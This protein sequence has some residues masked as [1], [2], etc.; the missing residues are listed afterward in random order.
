METT[1]ALLVMTRGVL[2]W[3][4]NTRATILFVQLCKLWRGF[5]LGTG[6]LVSLAIKGRS[7]LYGG[8]THVRPEREL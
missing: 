1:T 6:F 7:L 3:N 8:G 5:L 2:R 4:E